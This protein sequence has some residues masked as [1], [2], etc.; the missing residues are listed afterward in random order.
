MKSKKAGSPQSFLVKL[1][2]FLILLVVFGAILYTIRGKMEEGSLREIRRQNVKKHAEAHILGLDL[3]PELSFP[4]IKWNVKKGEEIEKSSDALVHDW[5]DLLRGEKEL[6]EKADKVYC[7][8]GHFLKFKNDK[9]IS[10]VELV[11]Y[12][13]TRN[14]DIIGEENI[15]ISEYLTGYTTDKT[16]FEEE[17]NELK[18]ELGN[19]EVVT[20]INNEDF[21]NPELLKEEYALNTEYDY[22]TVFVYMKEGY[23]PK[24][25][26][27]M[28]FGAG[29][30]IVGV[31][32][33]PLTGGGS[34][35]L[36][37]VPL[38][39]GATG[40]AIGYKTASDKSADWDTGI[41]LVPNK[42]E[43]LKDLKCDILPAKGEVE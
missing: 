28:V 1:L 11:N 18:S 38:A 27:T 29:G 40:G 25:L 23:W 41:F 26:K 20:I 17:M 35:M 2:I 14:V 37:I 8:P 15:P 3:S 32:L 16:V 34:L 4:V 9:K 13:R 22:M 39:T 42:A 33:V 5:Q 19:Q 36:A 10:A 30:V 24:W 12:Q 43:I 31:I 21:S 6:F 7:V